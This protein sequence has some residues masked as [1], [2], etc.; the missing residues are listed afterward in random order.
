MKYDGSGSAFT[1]TLFGRTNV[2]TALI[3]SHTINDLMFGYPSAYLGWVAFRAQLMQA[4]KSLTSPLSSTELSKRL[5]TGKM[6]ADLSFKL[7]NIANYTSKVGS[8][9]YSTCLKNG[10]CL[11]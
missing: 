7:G 9:C 1:A 4:R 8:V 6:D 3:Q 11:G 5:L 2:H 10:N